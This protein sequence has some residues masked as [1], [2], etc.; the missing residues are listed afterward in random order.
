MVPGP[1]GYGIPPGKYRISIF[2]GLTR[3]GESKAP[4]VHKGTSRK[5]PVINR[6]TDFLEGLFGPTTSPIV[7]K[8]ARGA[9]L[10]VDLDKESPAAKQ[11]AKQK[12]MEKR[13]REEQQSGD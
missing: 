12:K 11:A 7:R 9:E 8:M 4:K 5:A 2:Q 6:D 10:I 3:E 1:D 13:K